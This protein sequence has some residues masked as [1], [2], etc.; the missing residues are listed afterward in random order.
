[1]HDGAPGL[2][3]RPP[4]VCMP[5]FPL[6][7]LLATLVLSGWTVL[8]AQRMDAFVESRHHPAIAYGSTPPR[9][10][11]SM[12]NERLAR[13][14]AALSFDPATGYLPAVL[15]ALD[16]PRSSQ[17]LVYSPTSFQASHIRQDNPR[18]LY[19]NDTVAVGWVRGAELLE[20]T[21]QDPAQGT[22]FYAISQAGAVVAPALSRQESCVSCHLTYDTLGVPGPT[23]RTT[24]PRTRADDFLNGRPV[25]HARPMADRWGG[26][27]VTGARV[28][29]EHRGN[30]PLLQPAPGARPPALASVTGQFDL[31]GYLA[32]TSDIVAL[33]VLEHQTHATNLMTRLNWEARLGDPARVTAAV[34]ALADYLLFVDEVALEPVAGNTAFAAEFEARGPLDSRGRS[35]RDLRLDGRLMT[36]P[37]SYMVYTPMF[38]ALP[39]AAREQ[40][41]E[42]LAAVLSGRD[43]AAK[44]ARLPLADRLAALE[45][46]RA[47]KSDLPTALR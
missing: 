4:V 19:F 27:W 14:E 33:L 43:T 21:A 29:A 23:L 13:G 9:T 2:T 11:V 38:D 37:L 30:L 34:E 42:R 18:A 17:V 25:D 10:A 45:V 35:L 44:Y 41:G 16:I 40:V 20:I 46:L 22:I 8:V 12:L 26:W 1:M 6:P 32:T 5:R 36:Y 3:P 39:A 28:P 15:A 7:V 24:Y 47:T 31:S